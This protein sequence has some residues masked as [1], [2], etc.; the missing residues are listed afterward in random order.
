MKNRLQSGF[1]HQGIL[2]LVIVVAIITAIGYKVASD[3]N[4]KANN[5]VTAGST[6]VPEG[7]VIKT[8]ADLDKAT[9]ALNSEDVDGNLNPD[10]LDQDVQSML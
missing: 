2:L 5:S 10:S 6:A 8:T 7:P 4:N 1:A 3:Q 9:Q